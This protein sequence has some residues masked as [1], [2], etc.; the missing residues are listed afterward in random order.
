M[1]SV[2]RDDELVRHY[3]RGLPPLPVPRALEGPERVLLRARLLAKLGSTRGAAARAERPLWAAG[4]L[5]PA[6]AGL[7]LLALAARSASSLAA[8]RDPVGLAAV[9]GLPQLVAFALAAG[10]ALAVAIVLPLVLVEE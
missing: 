3:L 8:A 1:M 5:G 6:L 7:A 4:I 9:S 2:D 10:L